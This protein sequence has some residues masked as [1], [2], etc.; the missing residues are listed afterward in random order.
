M[1]P[2]KIYKHI[3]FASRFFPF[4]KPSCVLLVSHLLLL[5]IVAKLGTPNQR[6][7]TLFKF[8]PE[9]RQLGMLHFRMTM[10]SSLQAED[11]EKQ[12]HDV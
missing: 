1:F 7:E 5:F 8:I 2:C 11:V 12:C 9:L 10:T 3:R 6:I 4:E